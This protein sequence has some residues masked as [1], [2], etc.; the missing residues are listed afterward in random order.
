MKRS[1]RALTAASLLVLCAPANAEPTFDWG[2]Q[3]NFSGF[4]IDQ[5]E[6]VGSDVNGFGFAG[7]G[8]VWGRVRNVTDSGIEYGLRAQLRFQSSEHEFSNDSIRGAPDFVDEVWVYVQTAFGR[9]TI[10][11]EDGA[12]DSAGIYSPAVSDINRIDD[13]RAFVIQDPL[14]PSFAAFEPHGAHLR[15]DLNASGDALKVI[16]YSPRLIGVQLSASYTPDLRRGLDEL[17]DDS[18]SINRQEDIWEVGVNYQGSLS[19]FD[20]GF[21]AGYVSGSNADPAV[22]VAVPIAGVAL[23]SLPFVPDDLEEWGAGAQVVYE[24]LKVGGSYRSTNIAGGAGLQDNNFGISPGCWGALK[25][26]VVPDAR[27]EIWGAGIE[28]E[29][30]PW[31]FGANYTALTEELPLVNSLLG[32]VRPDDQKAHAWSGAVGYEFDENLRMGVGYQ[33]YR[34]NGP[35]NV[36]AGAACDTL[37]ADVAYFETAFSF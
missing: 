32:P 16:Y 31:S 35:A 24:G 2:G 28:Y 3:G 25:G 34:F 19:S 6:L 18:N 12:A 29:T 9:L 14:Q 13:A 4:W 36:C 23:G 22:A 33:H 17:F 8:K 37:D 27:T 26:C 30:G 1:W 7:E 21:Y 10:G 20:V 5:D 15:T 11:L